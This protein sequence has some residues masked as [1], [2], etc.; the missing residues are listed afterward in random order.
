MRARALSIL[1]VYAGLA[2]A[3]VYFTSP[4]RTWSAYVAVAGFLLNLPFF[5]LLAVV[6][7]GA[8][9]KGSLP[10]MRGLAWLVV[11]L[12]PW[13][14]LSELRVRARADA[15]SVPTELSAP[16]GQ[17]TAVI[18]IGI[19]IALLALAYHVGHVG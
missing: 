14:A 1:L 4:Q 17:T 6:M 3:R 10:V 19:M 13:Y 5:P 2:P 9:A 18:A 15:R 12:P 7:F 16:L 11:F 8:S